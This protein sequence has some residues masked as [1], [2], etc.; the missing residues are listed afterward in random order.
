MSYLGVTPGGGAKLKTSQT[1]DQ[2]HVPWHITAVSDSLGLPLNLGAMTQTVTRNVDGLITAITASDGVNSWVQT[3]TYVD[4][5]LAS[6][7]PWVKQ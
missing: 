6:V 2:E 5:A 7:G 1:G 3:L 4:G